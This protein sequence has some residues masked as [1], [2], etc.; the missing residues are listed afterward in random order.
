MRSFYQFLNESKNLHMQHLEDSVLYKGVSGVRDAIDSLRN[1]RD[2][3]S[4]KKNSNTTISIKF[5]GAPAVFCGIDPRDGEFFVAKKGLF[6]KTPKVYKS[7][8]DVRADTSGDLADK[9]SAAY[10]ELKPLGIKGIIQG[11]FMFSKSDLR[12]ETIDGQKMITFHPNTIVY[13]VPFDSDLGKEIRAAKI[14]I[15]WHTTYNGNNLESMSAS[16][17]VN[18]STIKRS[19]SVWMR[20]AEYRDSSGDVFISD[21][22]LREINKALSIAGKQFRRVASKDLK[23]LERD[24][25]QAQLIEQFNNTKVRSNT[26][27]TNARKHVDEFF[28]WLNGRFDKDLAKA[29]SDAGKQK[30]EDRRNDTIKYYKSLDLVAIYELQFALATAKEIVINQLS[31]INEIATFIKTR[32]G[33]KVTGQ[34]GFVAINSQKGDA[35]KLVDR[36]SFSA[37]NFN[38][39]VIKGWDR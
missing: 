18:M 30:I 33:F 38:P 5:D 11:D 2:M 9:L 23:Q 10:V 12:T 31:K 24:K 13:A 26:K 35:V 8:E 37:N 25:T 39:E 7:V 14:G 3:L 27:V 6:N 1:I 28:D 17:G 21:S 36:L 34:E 4:G 15:V 22:D 32:D 16:F 19:K 20:D 29:K